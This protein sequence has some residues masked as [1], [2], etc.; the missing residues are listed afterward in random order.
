MIGALRDIAGEIGARLVQW[1]EQGAMHGHW[2]GTQFK[3][4]ADTMAHRAWLEALAVLAPEI[5]VRSEEGEPPGAALCSGP[6]FLID[7][8]D[9]TA[10]YAH[11]FPGYVTQVAL[12]ESGRP[13]LAVVHA[14]VFGQTWHSVR[15]EGAFLNDRLLVRNDGEGA[16]MLL[17]DNYPEPRGV[18]ATL[19]RDLPA[20]GYVESGSIGLKACRVAD[21]SVDLFV[22]D[23]VVRDWDL[24][25]CDLILHEAGCWISDGSG[26][27]LEYDSNPE[28]H[29]VIAA[30]DPDVAARALE[31]V[32]RGGK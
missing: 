32:K 2:E 23:V 14:P 16:R 24:A 26:Q 3:A 21:G 12:M 6:Y 17:I 5:P 4:E 25:P 13:T 29:G 31:I 18:A 15:G 19:V 20:S 9:G 8:I 7:P 22:K 11:G 10:S 1:R 27:A 28:I 30:R